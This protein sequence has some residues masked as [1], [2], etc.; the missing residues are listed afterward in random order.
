MLSAKKLAYQVNDRHIT[1]IRDAVL[2]VIKV[3]QLENI[4]E[5]HSLKEKDQ[6]VLAE[7]G[8]VISYIFKPLPATPAGQATF[9]NQASKSRHPDYILV[10]CVLLVFCLF[11]KW[12]S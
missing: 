7:K 10:I 12:S 3:A 4:K 1:I 6:Y 11:R 5:G 9:T 2:S 8:D